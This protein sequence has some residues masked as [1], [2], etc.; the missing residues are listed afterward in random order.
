[1]P[2][3]MEKARQRAEIPVAATDQDNARLAEGVAGSLTAMTLVQLQTENLR[4]RFLTID[5]V[6]PTLENFESGK[7][8]YG[9]DLHLVVSSRT[10]P[11]LDRFVAF[12]HSP[13]GIA[14]LRASGSL[15]VRR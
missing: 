10:T 14:I 12:L 6:A 4:L 15:P 1:M 8:P 2:A 3:A 7:Y 13:R 5:G 11:A 9:K